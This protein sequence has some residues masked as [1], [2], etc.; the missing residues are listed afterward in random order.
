MSGFQCLH[1]SQRSVLDPSTSMSCR[2]CGQ[3]QGVACRWGHGQSHEGRREMSL[4]W[5]FDTACTYRSGRQSH[6][7][8]AVADIIPMQNEVPA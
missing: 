2:A 1:C 6:I 8:V 7:W 4:Y 5:G 3:D